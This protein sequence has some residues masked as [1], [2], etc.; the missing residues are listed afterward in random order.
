[1]QLSMLKY[2]PTSEMVYCAWL[3]EAK[4]F[5]LLILQDVPPCF[6]TINILISTRR[7]YEHEK[8]Q[9]IYK[10]HEEKFVLNKVYL[11]FFLA[12]NPIVIV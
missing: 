2:H 11:F 9:K 10:E 7:H 5:Q 4:E 3:V 6:A 1:M 12:A 8:Q